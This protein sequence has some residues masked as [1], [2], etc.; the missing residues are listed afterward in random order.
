MAGES[1]K[2]RKEL[3]TFKQST[4]KLS[5]KINSVGELWRDEGY[6]S[7]QAQMSELAKKSRTVI[8]H[9]ERACSS[10]EKFF[11]IAAEEV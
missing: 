3:E 1:L 9:G 6:V 11:T 5:N 10:T 8:E 4:A 7:L 2:I